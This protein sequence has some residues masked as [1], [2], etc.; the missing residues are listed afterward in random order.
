[1]MA[2]DFKAEAVAFVREKNCAAHTSV[3]L[4]QAA[5]EAAAVTVI[6]QT[7][8]RLRLVREELQ[9]QRERN[10]TGR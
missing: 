9:R 6:A 5:M 7:T 2:F 1:M 10:F 3:E 8:D 4:V